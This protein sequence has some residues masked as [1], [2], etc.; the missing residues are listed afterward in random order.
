MNFGAALL[1]GVDSLVIPLIFTVALG[2]FT[3][4][5]IQFYIQGTHDDVLKH[6]SIALIAYSVAGLVAMGVLW[7]GIHIFAGTLGL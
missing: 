1:T 2:A 6:K 7:A 3:Y 5:T 4:G